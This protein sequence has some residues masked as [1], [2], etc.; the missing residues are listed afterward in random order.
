M[1]GGEVRASVVRMNP[2][3]LP[4]LIGYDGS[5]CARHAIEVAGTL[6]PG[7]AAIVFFAWRP[8]SA[9]ATTRASLPVSRHA[10]KVARCAALRIAEGG[11]ALASR[12][13]LAARA[14]IAEARP[15]RWQAILQAA[16]RADA[17]V[18]VVGGRGKTGFESAMLG[19]VSD[20]VARHSQRPVLIAP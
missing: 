9:P 14:D 4:L 10:D 2:E 5:S 1:A 3:S 19:A 7:R 6:W 20:G 13:G 11:A 12:A 17:G 15:S 16:D 18:V 8:I